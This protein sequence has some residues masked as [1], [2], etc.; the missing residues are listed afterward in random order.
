[1]GKKVE[2]GRSY[3][4]EDKRIGLTPKKAIIQISRDN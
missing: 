4:M 2:T 1:M 3:H